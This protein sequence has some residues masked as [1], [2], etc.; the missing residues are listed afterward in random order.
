M[1]QP[2]TFKARASN[3]AIRA[4]FDVEFGSEARHAHASIDGMIHMI[5]KCDQVVARLPEPSKTQ[6]AHV[7]SL[8]QKSANDL[9]A[10]LEMLRL[11]YHT[12]AISILRTAMETQALS[13]LV[14]AD[15]QVF[16]QYRENKFSSKDVVRRFLRLKEVHMDPDAKQQFVDAH[17]TLGY[18]VHPTA[19]SVW[20]Q[21]YAHGPFPVG[22]SFDSAKR[23]L[24]EKHLR[25]VS[26]LATNM[27][28]I[29]GTRFML[30]KTLE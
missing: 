4:R 21:F 30:S 6:Q 16:V 20:V 1:G 28:N 17:R 2:A 12:C 27:S 13:A 3:A 23:E 5:R 19:H 18:S 24:Y 9:L 25:N 29:L 10:S 7:L 8:A 22:S 14:S 26:T 11:G 15:Q